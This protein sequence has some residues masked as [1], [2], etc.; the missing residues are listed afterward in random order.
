MHLLPCVIKLV[1]L[2]CMLKRGSG[3]ALGPLGA[4]NLKA[5]ASTSSLEAEC[6]LPFVIINFLW[7]S[8]RACARRLPRALP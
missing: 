3:L 2:R 7:A 6:M 8:R 5:N 1:T 4:Y